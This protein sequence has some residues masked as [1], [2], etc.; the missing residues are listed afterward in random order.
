MKNVSLGT[1][2]KDYYSDY[3]ISE[4][5]RLPRDKASLDPANAFITNPYFYVISDLLGPSFI[6][7]FDSNKNITVY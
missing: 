5:L 1:I 6:I 3:I 2:M 4:N 7:E